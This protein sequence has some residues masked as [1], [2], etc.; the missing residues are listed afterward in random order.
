MTSRPALRRYA[1]I[2][3]PITH[4]RSPQIHA[5]FAA[6]TGISLEYERIPAPLD[7]FRATAEA[8]FLAGGQGLN[9]TVPFKQE[10]FELAREHLSARARMAGAVNTLT[11][12]D[13][14]LQGCNTDGVGL[15]N[16]LIRL[17]VML[18]GARLLLVGAG[19]AARGVLQPLAEAGCAEIRIVNRS[20]GRAAELLAAWTASGIPGGVQTSAGALDEAGGAWDIVINATASSLHDL[21]PALPGG[22]YAPGALAYDMVYG[23]R[24][25][26]FMRQ[27]RA[28]GAALTADGL[29]MLV[30]QAAESFFIWHGLRPDPTAVLTT[31]RAN[32][33]AE[34]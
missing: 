25:T 15:V 17:G 21:A 8:F 6:Q 12:R 23:A 27:A 28:D 33:L 20:P 24:P 7:G 29:G 2:G 10:A 34:D 11:W 26:P 3:N 32:L 22:L 14:V 9:V 1:V 31:L 30:G 13:G 5:M 16:D 18:Q 4:S 19:G